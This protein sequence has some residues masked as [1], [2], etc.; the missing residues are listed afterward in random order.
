MTPERASTLPAEYGVE[1]KKQTTHGKSFAVCLQQLFIKHVVK[2][3]AK[4]SFCNQVP[5]LKKYVTLYMSGLKGIPFPLDKS[6]WTLD[7][8]FA[9]YKAWHSDLL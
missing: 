2:S 8:S 3:S 6:F 1:K 5:K 7:N 9:A 4:T